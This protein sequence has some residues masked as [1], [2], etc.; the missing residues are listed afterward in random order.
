MLQKKLFSDD[1]DFSS[2]VLWIC[3]FSI[4]IQQE[5]LKLRQQTKKIK[6]KAYTEKQQKDSLQLNCLK[7]IVSLLILTASNDF[8]KT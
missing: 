4:R 5:R 2:R 8:E 3:I 7:G 1:N 6:L